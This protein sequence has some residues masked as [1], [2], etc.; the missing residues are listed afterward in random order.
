MKYYVDCRTA[1]G[2]DGSENKPFNKI[3]QAADI[4][5]A[6]DEVIVA[7]GIYREYVDP[8]NAGEEGKPIVYRSAKPR[9][10]HITGAEVLSGWTKVDGTVYTARVSNKIFGDYNPYTTLVS[11]DWFIAYFIAHTG[12][13]YLNGKSMYE[14]QSLDEVKKAEP[15]DSA[16]DT[17]FSRYKWYAEQDTSKDETVFYVNFL[18]RDPSKDNIEISVRRN[19]F[20]PSK[21]GVGYIT[22]NGF[23][24]S[25][26]ATQWAP[27]TAYQEGMVGPHWSK[28]WIIEDCE[29]Y[30]SKCSG[31]SLGKYL[32]PEND[33]K[34]LKTKYKDGTQTE[35]DCICQAQVEGWS[36]ERIGSHIIRNCEIHDCG[37]TGIVGHLGGVFSLIENN[38]IHHINN[39]QNLAGAEIGGI[40][41]H[42]AID[43]IYRRNHIHHCTRG[44]WLDWQ[45]QGTRVTQ[46]FFHDN[47]PPQHPGKEIKAEVAEDLFIE[48]SH[49]P[50]LVDNNIFLSPRALKLATQGVA[51]IHNILAGSFTAVGRGCNNGAPNRPSPRYTPYHM[52]HRTEVAGFMTI[53]HG[54]CKFYNNI[55]I[56]KPICDEFKARMV[57]NEKNDWDDSNFVV[58]TVPYN[59]YPTFDEWKAQFEGYCGMGSE[60]TDRYYSEL[61]VWA[62]GNLYFNGAKPMSKEADAY[63]NSENN[64]EIDCEEKDGKI[65]LKTNLYELVSTGKVPAD[66]MSCK[67]MHTEDIAPAFE[68][69]QNYE[70]PDGSPIIFNIDFF[71]KKRGEKPVAGPFA[72]KDEIKD[73]LF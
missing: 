57:A 28:G 45:A 35:R 24:V 7:P 17:E 1:A 6:G 36:K 58:G 54:D 33:N 13:V 29:I 18:G 25:Q 71:G 21:E 15:S 8:K 4:A 61:P 48:V 32:Q 63:V 70:N 68:P 52:K 43:C 10:A 23:V 55:F 60:T 26:A 14:V 2:G 72:D 30:E 31:I 9:E 49:G 53:L 5:V 69:E 66:A 11:G 62:G 39:K 46:N 51:V 67:L 56:Q 22:L 40:K 3:Q 50:T 20:Y 34:W 37:Q 59:N 16:W 12:D 19:G 41:M 47:I 64:V 38:H 42:A 73:S 27:P 65:Y 44:I